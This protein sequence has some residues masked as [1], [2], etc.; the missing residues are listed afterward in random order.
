MTNDDLLQQFDKLIQ[1]RLEANNKQLRLEVREDTKTA[2][3]PH[4]PFGVK[5]L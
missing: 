5:V 4:S 3:N 1:Q 2:I